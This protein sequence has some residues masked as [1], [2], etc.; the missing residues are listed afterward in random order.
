MSK[1]DKLFAPKEAVETLREQGEDELADDLATHVSNNI[2]DRRVRV[3][4]W[5]KGALYYTLAIGIPVCGIAA[6]LESAYSG[7]YIRSL[8]IL[9]VVLVMYALTAVVTN[10]ASGATEWFDNQSRE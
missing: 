8:V 4:R 3:T 1:K 10:A 9:A 6:V 5:V 7:A 2:N